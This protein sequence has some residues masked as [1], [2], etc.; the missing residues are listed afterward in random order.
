MMAVS[1]YA[2]AR[3]LDPTDEAL[4]HL[5]SLDPGASGSYEERFFVQGR[6][7]RRDGSPYIGAARVVVSPKRVGQR[8]RFTIEIPVTCDTNGDFEGDVWAPFEA[9]TGS[10]GRTTAWVSPA[11]NRGAHGV[12]SAQENGL[13]ANR[14]V[15]FQ[16]DANG[17]LRRTALGQLRL[18]DP[19]SIGTI[20]FSGPGNDVVEFS[21]RAPGFPDRYYEE[22][23]EQD[24]ERL[25]VVAGEQLELFSWFQRSD[26]VCTWRLNGWSNSGPFSRG[27]DN[28]YSLTAPGSVEVQFSPS[29][30][31]GVA[32]RV[33]IAVFPDSTPSFS[34]PLDASRT[35]AYTQATFHAERNA[36][37]F[38]MYRA[39]DPVLFEGLDPGNYRIEI[40]NPTQTPAGIESQQSVSVSPG[41]ETTVTF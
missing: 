40:W 32:S 21:V 6:L 16:R 34:P 12:Y 19:G 22:A 7:L 35:K 37:G 14:M 41:S 2:L 26:W 9:V 29:Y 5:A 31:G 1:A 13:A 39:G 3:W 15:S 28:V 20:E 10:E 27:A 36:S 4:D 33:L 23:L 18:S 38:Y 17:T 11:S 25:E 30:T 24:G 8:D